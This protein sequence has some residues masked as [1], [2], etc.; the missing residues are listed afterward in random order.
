MVKLNL[1]AK[2][3]LLGGMYAFLLYNA[4]NVKKLVHKNIQKSN[5]IFVQFVGIQISGMGVQ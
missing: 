1:G 3:E 5:E 2:S 4:K